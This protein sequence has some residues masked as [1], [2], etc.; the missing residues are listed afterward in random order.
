LFFS[1]IANPESPASTYGTNWIDIKSAED[2]TDPI[3]WLDVV[4]DTLIVFK[5]RSVWAV[6]DPVNFSNRRIGSPGCEDRF[7]SVELYGVLFYLC[8]DGI[9]SVD[10]NT[11]PEYESRNLGPIFQGVGN[12]VG[13]INPAAWSTARLAASRDRRLFVALPIG[14]STVNNLLLEGV[15]D[16]RGIT[17]VS[18]RRITGDMPWMPHDFPCASLATFRSVN[19]DD[20]V[21]GDSGAA[22]LHKLFS[23]TND[24]GAA[25]TSYWMGPWAGALTEEPF[26][27]VRRV[28][29]LRSGR[30]VVDLFQ[31]LKSDAAVFSQV[32]EAPVDP[33]P[34]WDGGVWD[35]G[36]WDPEASLGLA[37]MRPEKRGRYHALQFRND[38]LDKTFTIYTAELAIRGG[39]EHT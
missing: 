31:D 14:S 2:D 39:K 24:D 29:V 35:G 34:L 21:A 26:E 16:L 28:N 3:T 33:D 20:L 8:R 19:T 22:E 15:P 6:F 1:D 13:I 27:R 18:G 37:R 4:Q 5:K 36:T 17:H 32:L 9:Y 12:P 30:V 25:I 23:G 7:Q 10:P 38:V 11:Y